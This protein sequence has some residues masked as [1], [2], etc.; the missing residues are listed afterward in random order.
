MHPQ[1]KNSL[2][3]LCLLA[4]EK[5]SCYSNILRYRYDSEKRECDSFN[6]TGCNSNY[7]N[8]V[9]SEACDRAC[10]R[11]RLQD[12]C[13]QGPEPGNCQLKVPKWYYDSAES[14]C[15]VF[16]WSGCDGNGN[17]FSSSEECLNLCEKESKAT[18]NRDICSLERDSG[19]CQDATT[20]WYFDSAAN[21][22]KRF[23]YGGCRGNTNRF[24]SKDACLRRCSSRIFTTETPK[25]PKEICS[26]PFEAGPCEG[27][28]KKWFFDANAGRC[29][30][31][32]Y[33]GCGGNENRYDDEADCFNACK[34]FANLNH[35]EHR[36]RPRV[37][38]SQNGAYTAG[39]QIELRC[40]YEATNVEVT[41]YRQICFQSVGNLL[42]ITN[43]K[44]QDAGRYSCSPEKLGILSEP[45][46][47]DV[48]EL[49]TDA[50][51]DSGTAATCTLVKRSGLCANAR[52]GRYCCRTCS[53]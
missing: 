28:E 11:F 21:D 48:K 25:E 9:S 50:C 2:P 39:S 46:S 1:T 53:P 22:C 18:R 51:S 32:T 23:T 17:R 37:L 47:V 31:F 13:S 38:A 29:R 33:S 24:V 40:L 35:L 6:Y 43:S 41:W 7:N 10:G 49:A 27:I 42:K 8:F 36:A 4:E 20:M 16:Y 3:E 45:L 34:Q 5:G 12:V 44:V 19:P 15:K 26:L 30:S 14:K 52:Y